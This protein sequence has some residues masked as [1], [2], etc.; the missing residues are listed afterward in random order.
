MKKKLLVFFFVILVLV[1]VFFIFSRYKNQLP[2][3]LF[4][5]DTQISI[6]IADTP[7]SQAR[8]LSGRS[9][10]YDIE[11]MLFLFSQDGKYGFWMKDMQFPIDIIWLDKD[12]KIT[13]VTTSIDPSTYPTIFYSQVPVRAVLEVSAGFSERHGVKTGDKVTLCP[14]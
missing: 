4:V 8:G 6:D 14:R 12:W 13:E 11:G 7:P 9:S 2:K 10:L 3:C 5:G 1:A